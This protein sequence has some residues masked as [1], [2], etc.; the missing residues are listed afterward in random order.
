MTLFSFLTL[1]LS[2][3]IT[4]SL[5]PDADQVAPALKVSHYDCSEMTENTLYAFNQV[6]LCHIT[7]EEFEISNARITIYTIPFRKELNATKCRIQHHREKWH[8]GLLDHS[9]TDHTIAGITSDFIISTEHCRTLAK[10]ASINLQGHW[11]GAE[12]DTKTSVVKVSG[13][14]TGSNRNHCKTGG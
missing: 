3:E 4:N 11:L 10:G 8:C 5:A 1:V 6:R 9:S 13:D 14:P 12:W 2:A 7:P